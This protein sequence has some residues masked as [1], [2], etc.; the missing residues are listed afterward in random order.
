MRQRGCRVRI[1]SCGRVGDADADRQQQ[2]RRYQRRRTMR[3]AGA[4]AIVR[5]IAAAFVIRRGCVLRCAALVHAVM[6][7]AVMS[8]AVIGQGV[9]RHAVVRV[10]CGRTHVFVAG[11]FGGRFCNGDGVVR[12]SRM[13]RRHRTT[14]AVRHQGEAEQSMQQERAKAHGRSV[15]PA[16]PARSRAQPILLVCAMRLVTR[17]RSSPVLA[18]G[19]SRGSSSKRSVHRPAQAFAHPHEEPFRTRHRYLFFKPATTSDTPSP[20]SS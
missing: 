19:E 1:G 7:H 9:I 17:C 18:T 4:S 5:T 6:G 2:C 3:N 8:R 20:S 13:Y 14:D 12:T 16:Y 10:R 15:L 11:R